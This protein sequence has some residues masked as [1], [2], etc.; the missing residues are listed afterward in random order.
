MRYSWWSFIGGGEMKYS[1]TGYNI[2]NL[3]KIL[4][5]KKITLYNVNWTSYNEISFEVD[6]KQCKKVKRYIS[7]FKEQHKLTGIKKLPSIL[8][9]NI[10]I[11]LAVFLGVLFYIFASQFTWQIMVYGTKELSESQILNVLKEKRR[12]TSAV[13]KNNDFF[14]PL[15]L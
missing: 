13:K 6:D 8:L 4:H 2:D 3:L 1:L 7:N 12:L 9:A 15:L 14:I 5:A 10:G 11:V